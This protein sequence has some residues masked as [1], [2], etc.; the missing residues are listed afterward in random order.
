LFPSLPFSDE[1]G[2]VSIEEFNSR[3]NRPYPVFAP[4]YVAFR[5]QATS[6][7]HLGAQR[8]EQMNLVVDGQPSAIT[9]LWVTPDLL[10]AFGVGTILG[11]PFTAD[12]YHK[13]SEGTVVLLSYQTWQQQFGGEASVIGREILIGEKLRRVVGVMPAAVHDWPGSGYWNVC[14]P[15]AEE[16]LDDADPG[17]AFSTTLGVMGRLKQGVTLQQAQAELA[18][19]RKP[20]GPMSA[21]WA[22]LSPQVIPIR[23]KYVANASQLFWVFLGAVACLYAISC[24][25]AV[26][27]MLVRTVSRRRELGVRLALGGS[28]LQLGWYGCFLPRA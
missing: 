18:A 17:M 27:L 7:A 15:L 22:P 28:H 4:R 26:N 5:T 19:T 10:P 20:A 24:A 25:N 21:F 13:G 3:E 16:S 23:E 1:T 6:F 2:L 11:R 9:A 8:S 14:L 12:E